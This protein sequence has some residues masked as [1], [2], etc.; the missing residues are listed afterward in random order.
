M[1]RC[2]SCFVLMTRCE[3]SLPDNGIMRSVVCPSCYGTW[4]PHS[5]LARRASMDVKGGNGPANNA[6]PNAATMQDLAAVVSASDTKEPLRCP[7]CEK[8]MQKTRFHPLIPV[9]IDRCKVCGGTWL[10]AGEMPMIRRLYVELINSQ[11]PKIVAMRDKLAESQSQ[12]QVA[13]GYPQPTLNSA[14]SFT[15]DALL[16]LL[17]I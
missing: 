10:D 16:D 3:E 12:R 14:V 6:G 11:D 1:P 2:P 4:L 7:A 8:V 9:T 17:T 5:A 15:L 13:T